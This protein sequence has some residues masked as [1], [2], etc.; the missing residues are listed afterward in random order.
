MPKALAITRD[1]FT[2]VD[3]REAARRRL[4]ESARKTPSGS[5]AAPFRGTA[6]SI[7]GGRRMIATFRI[8]YRVLKLRALMFVLRR[9]KARAKR[10]S[11]PER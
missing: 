4:H 1:D 2:A 3:F 7:C 5:Y 8:R 10:L 9:L 6:G 11:R